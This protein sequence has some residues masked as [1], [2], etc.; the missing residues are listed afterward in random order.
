MHE[1]SVPELLEQLAAIVI[2]LQ[3]AYQKQVVKPARSFENWPAAVDVHSIVDESDVEMI[4]VR[5]I[6]IIAELSAHYN[7][8]TS[9]L[10]FGCG[11]GSIAA[12]M[13]DYVNNSIGYDV[14]HSEH[15]SQYDHPNLKLTDDP[16][17]L[18]QRA[19]FN[20]ILLYDVLDHALD[21]IDVLKQVAGMLADDGVVVVRVHPWV[22]RHGAHQYLGFN[23]AFAHLVL[24][25]AELLQRGVNVKY[26]QRVI[27]PLAT[28]DSWF[29]TAGLA[30]RTRKAEIVEPE[31]FFRGQVLD[32]IIKSVWDGKLDAVTARKI[33]SNNFIDYVLVK[34]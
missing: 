2:K 10:D 14:K 31:P 25:D 34:E 23:R 7:D 26:S 18:I 27:R 30:I 9:F 28:Y 12:E 29:G 8:E 15:W 33:M 22:S 32:Q 13:A 11:N 16:M 6:Q 21:P 17:L 20:L 1:P 3:S 5:A 4:K 19:P 24:S